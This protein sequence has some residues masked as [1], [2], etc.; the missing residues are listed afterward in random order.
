M[1]ELGLLLS[2][3]VIFH[4]AVFMFWIFFWAQQSILNEEYTAPFGLSV[5]YCAVVAPSAAVLNIVDGICVLLWGLIGIC[6]FYNLLPK[7]QRPQRKKR[8]KQKQNP[9][10]MSRGIWPG[11]P[12]P[13]LG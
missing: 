8:L 5:I 7:E 10:T 12:F 9:T 13:K 6:L 11:K 3:F 1:N 2:H 4:G